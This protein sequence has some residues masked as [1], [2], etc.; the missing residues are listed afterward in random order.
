MDDLIVSS[1]DP[2][3][4]VVAIVRENGSYEPFEFREK[5]RVPDGAELIEVRTTTIGGA[6][7]RAQNLLRSRD[8][9]AYVATLPEYQKVAES[10]YSLD[11]DESCQDL[12]LRTYLARA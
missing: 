11:D 10:P 12:V 4:V 3:E 2:G 9:V 5:K 8:G 7:K 1:D 6:V